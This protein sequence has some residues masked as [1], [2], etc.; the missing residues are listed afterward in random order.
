MRAAIA[1]TSLPSTGRGPEAAARPPARV[2][3]AALA[4]AGGGVP[5]ELD[6]ELGASA[7]IRSRRDRKIPPDPTRPIGCFQE[8]EREPDGTLTPVLTV[9]LAGAECPFTC[10]FCD[11]W[12][13]TLDGPTPRGAIPRQ[14]A[15]ALRE[16]GTLPPAGAAKLYNA[17]NFFDARAVPP[18]DDAAIAELLRPFHRVTVECHPRLV[19]RRCLEFAGRIPGRLEVAMGLESADPEVLARLNKGMTLADFE[20]AAAT[21]RRAGLG[22]RVFVLLPPPYVPAGQAVESVLY[23]VNYAIDRGAAHVALIPTR[24]GN[25]ELDDLRAR[26]DSVPPTRGFIDE[27]VERCEKV[28]ESVVTIDLWDIDRL[29]ACPCCRPA[30]TARL[31][32]FN[33]TGQSGSRVRCSACASSS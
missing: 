26:G 13:R 20:R 5:A 2:S 24:H 16:A 8:D 29:A 17:S 27:V 31:R 33:R 28:T 9:L 22:L 3:D 12:R 32:R 1:A 30:W 18:Q 11:L 15:T 19:G 21:L 10:V 4:A 7:R 14:L 23:S 6:G 25:G